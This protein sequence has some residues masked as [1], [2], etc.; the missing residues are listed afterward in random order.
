MCHVPSVVTDLWSQ[1]CGPL[2]SCSELGRYKGNCKFLLRWFRNGFSWSSYDLH[3]NI[4]PANFFW[5]K[6]VRFSPCRDRDFRKRPGYFQIFPTNF[7]T[8]PNVPKIKCPQM[9]QKTFEHFRSYLR[10]NFKRASIWF[11]LNRKRDSKSSCVLRT[12]CP[13]LWTRRE[14]LSLMCGSM[15]FSPKA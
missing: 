8:L 5:V 6:C 10:R 3:P 14:K 15:S 9:F 12:I 11:R 1:I 13:E 2:N 4:I 7:R